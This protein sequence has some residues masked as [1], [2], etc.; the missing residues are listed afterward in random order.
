M[1]LACSLA[2]IV[3]YCLLSRRSEAYNAWHTDLII[4]RTG[5]DRRIIRCSQVIDLPKRSPR[6]GALQMKSA[7]LAAGSDRRHHPR[8]R[9]FTP[10]WMA[11]GGRWQPETRPRMK[12]LWVS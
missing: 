8:C 10:G 11:P 1:G 4:G 5:K 6:S 12:P 3:Q 7:M 9:G 2:R